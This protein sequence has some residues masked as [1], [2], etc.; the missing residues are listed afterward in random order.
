MGVMTPPKSS[1]KTI[2]I[3]G[4][5]AGIGQAT[6]R[7][8]ARTFNPVHLILTG[9]REDRLLDLKGELEHGHP[10]VKVTTLTFDVS[11]TDETS[12]LLS[13]L[14]TQIPHLNV[15]INNAGLALGRDTIES[16]DLEDVRTMFETN[17]LG[18]FNVT[19]QLIPLL[20]KSSQAHIIN[21]GSTAAKQAYSHGGAYCATKAAVDTLSKTL[22]IELLKDQIKVTAIH[23]GAV[24]TEF[25]VVRFKGDTEKANSVYQGF[26]PLVAEDVA[27]VILQTL[28]LPSHV[29]LNDIVMSSIHQAD[30][31]HF[32]KT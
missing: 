6:A 31:F 17:V 27:Q 18:F 11:N 10:E 22:R 20:R 13:H 19:K 9:R 2:L 7:L 30:A 4:A 32:H 5:T 3:T 29:C 25:S 1:L 15:L 24:E 8:L 12:T 26:K 14:E 21:I 23:P 16:A 28:S